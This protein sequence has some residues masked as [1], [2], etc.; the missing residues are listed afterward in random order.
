[1]SSDD[2]VAPVSWVALKETV[3]LIWSELLQ[4]QRTYESFCQ[5][6]VF[7]EE[8]FIRLIDW[9]GDAD[10]SIIP[11]DYL[12][13]IGWTGELDVLPADV[14]R[15]SPLHQSLIQAINYMGNV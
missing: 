3:L 1:M 10:W 9:N 13:S 15:S 14:L 12:S 11:S 2:C 5:E 8:K 6:L 7:D 4:G